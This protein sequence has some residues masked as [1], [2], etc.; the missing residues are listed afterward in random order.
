D[1]VPCFAQQ[2]VVGRSE[3]MQ[4]RVHDRKPAVAHGAVHVDDRVTGHTAEPVLSFWSLHLVL[5]RLLKTSVEE[6]GV[7]VATGAPFAP[8][9][10]A[11]LLHM[12]DGAAI[13]AVVE[14][15]EVVH[16]ALPLLVDILVT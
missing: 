8:L 13:K 12:L 9:C 5:D 15:R 6:N 3:A 16:R 1:K 7:I 4:G 14:G 11:Q 10:A 2:P